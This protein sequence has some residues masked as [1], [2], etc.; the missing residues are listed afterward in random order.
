MMDQNTGL[1][2]HVQFIS[3]MQQTSMPPAF[4]D[5]QLGS[6]T[7]LQ[8]HKIADSNAANWAVETVTTAA[9]L[10]DSK[11]TRLTATVAG[12]QAQPVS[13]TVSLVLDNKVVASK[14]VNIAANGRAQVE[15]LGFDVPYGSHRAQVR[16]EPHDKLPSDDS[17]PFSVERSDPRRVLFLYAGGRAREAFYYK[18]AMESAADTGLTV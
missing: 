15:F 2:L 3:D 4:R 5:L 17:F 9:H 18:A 16:L 1:E 13:R 14:D 12:W 10:Y 6:H 8:L 11:H 7:A